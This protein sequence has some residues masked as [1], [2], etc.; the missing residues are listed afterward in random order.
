MKKRAKKSECKDGKEEI[1]GGVATG[2]EAARLLAA[3][4]A[5]GDGGGD[6]L[7]EVGGW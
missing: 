6:I 2:R 4:A 7:E 5:G 1:N 3:A